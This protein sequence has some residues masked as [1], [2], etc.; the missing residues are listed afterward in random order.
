[1]A[2]ADEAERDWAPP[3]KRGARL[4]A[5]FVVLFLVSLFVFLYWSCTNVHL[6]AAAAANG[7]LAAMR[8]EQRSQG[9]TRFCTSELREHI[10]RLDR[11]NPKDDEE[12]TLVRLMSAEPKELGSGQF[13]GAF[14]WG[15]FTTDL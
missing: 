10:D 14:T 2:N 4:I 13:G 9:T 15:C 5:I 6:P 1:M 3:T 11:A 7:F 12:R 8:T